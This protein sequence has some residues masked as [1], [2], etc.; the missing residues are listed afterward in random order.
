LKTK[1]LRS[2][3]SA[4]IN[5]KVCRRF[6]GSENR[7]GRADKCRA[8]EPVHS[9]SIS[10]RARPRT[11]ASQ[12]NPRS[13]AVPLPKT[14]I[15]T[16]CGNWQRRRHFRSMGLRGA[17]H[18]HWLKGNRLWKPQAR[19]FRRLGG[20]SAEGQFLQS[21]REY[22]PRVKTGQLQPKKTFVRTCTLPTM[23]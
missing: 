13:S 18:L 2:A 10:V 5:R 20:E 7:A 16:Y 9:C 23:S 21:F 14:S 4:R 6:W 12:G 1:R 11:N 17:D 3:S 8:A 19:I 22:P 15:R